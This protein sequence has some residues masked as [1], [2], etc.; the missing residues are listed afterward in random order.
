MWYSGTEWK[1]AMKSRVIGLDVKQNQGTV[2]VR[3]IR[4]VRQVEEHVKQN[5]QAIEKRER[6]KKPKK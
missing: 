6:K 1:K 2:W 5:K 4:S 3:S